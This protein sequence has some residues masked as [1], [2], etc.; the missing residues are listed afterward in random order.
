MVD[1][2]GIVNSTF[3]LYT[4]YKEIYDEMA[5]TGEAT[6]AELNS[7]YVKVV[8]AKFAK[9]NALSSALSNGGKMSW[10]EINSIFDSR[11][12]N[13]A[14][15]YDADTNKWGLWEEVE[16]PNRNLKVFKKD[17]GFADIFETD[18]WGNTYIKE[19]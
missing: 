11:N 19:G 6:V 9:A 12:L 10:S 14:D 7:T 16:N 1:G 8:E 13:I 4:V 5:A 3:D 18:I 15:Y 2:Q 17:A